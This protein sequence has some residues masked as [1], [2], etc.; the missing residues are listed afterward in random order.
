MYGNGSVSECLYNAILV[1]RFWTMEKPGELLK[2]L[3]YVLNKCFLSILSWEARREGLWR[4]AVLGSKCQASWPS[5]ITTLDSKRT[6]KGRDHVWWVERFAIVFIVFKLRS[7]HGCLATDVWVNVFTMPFLCADSGKWRKMYRAWPAMSAIT[8]SSGSTCPSQQESAWG[9]A[10]ARQERGT[11][12]VVRNGI[13]GGR[14]W[15][16]CWTRLQMFSVR[17]VLEQG[18]FLQGDQA[19]DVEQS[20]GASAKLPGRRPPPRWRGKDN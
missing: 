8:T 1:R 5:P 10:E 16:I 20:W 12:E 13:F 7:V 18:L 4:G 14:C 11:V 15:N 17:I 9:A 19:S 6:S 2:M 3:E